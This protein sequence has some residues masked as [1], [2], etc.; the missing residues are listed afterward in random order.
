MLAG[1]DSVGKVEFLKNRS[2]VVTWTAGVLV[3]L[4]LLAVVLAFSPP[5]MS[6]GSYVCARLWRARLATCRSLDDVR[7]R[8]R[9]AKWEAT[10]KGSCFFVEDPNTHRRGRTWA[11]LYE[12]P[13]GDW[14]AMAYRSSHNTWGGGTVVTRDSA[15]RIRVFFGHVCGSP[16]VFGESLDEVY[17]SL[18]NPSSRLREVTPGQ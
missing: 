12:F 6:D 9:C 17:A 18:V 14:L 1:G 4:G 11:L 3:F 7:E 15:G 2:R 13:D 16:N 8:F 10:G 5:G